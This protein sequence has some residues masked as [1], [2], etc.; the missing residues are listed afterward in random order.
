VLVDPDAER[1]FTDTY[2]KFLGIRLR[3][4]ELVYRSKLLTMH[5]AMASEVNVL[6]H[7]L[8]RLSESNRWYRDFTLNALTTAVREVIACFPVYR[9]YLVPGLPADEQDVRI[10][11]RALTAARRR[12]PAL[13]RTV[14][15]FLRNVL[16]P[17][18]EDVHPVDEES[19]RAFV[20]KFQQITGPITAKGVEDTAFYVYNRL[21]ALNEVG[22]DPAVFGASVQTFHQQNLS[23]A[24][25]FPHS[26]VATSTHDTKRSE[27]VRARIAA[28]SEMP[29]EWARLVRRCHT[30]NRKHRREIEGEFAPD[31]NEEFVLYQTLLGSWPLHPMTEEEHRTY[32]GRVQEYMMKALHEAKV[33]SSWIEP[34]EPWENAV[35]N[36]VAE[37]LDRRRSNPFMRNFLPAAERIA[38]LGAINSLAQTVLKL[39]VPGVPDIYQGNE[40]WDFSLVD[41]DNRRPVDYQHRRELLA[42]I[43][44]EVSPGDLLSNWKDGRIKLLVTQRL[45]RLRRDLA[46]LFTDGSY[47]PVEV[48]G[49]HRTSVI[50]FERRNATHR[51]LVVVPRL[52]SRVGF[53][54]VGDLWQET[55][56]QYAPEQPLRD[57]FFGREMGPDA[58]PPLSA[59]LA[60]FPVGVFVS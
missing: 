51:L 22:G 57:V 25:E 33:N 18:A 1:S 48:E 31:A 14:F 40:I 58:A 28:L 35:K 60:D 44:G 47:L 21:L 3:F 37:I 55:R 50:A 2:L 5:S 8:N 7:M 29:Q 59:L 49:T 39:T 13:E 46:A 52:S 43:S 53:P 16:L 41:P 24:A 20:L 54:P 56:L 6:G 11:E 32:V 10:I 19:R 23:R 27:D 36:F 12:N 4:D 30:A 26:M 9:T 45:L 38:E 15:S 34:N 42:S 17:P